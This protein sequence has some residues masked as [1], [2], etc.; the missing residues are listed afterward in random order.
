MKKI[1][2]ILLLLVSLGGCS[3][4]SAFQSSWYF[5]DEEKA[6][7]ETYVA[8]LNQG[9]DILRVKRVILNP[10]GDEVQDGWVRDINE[11]LEPGQVLLRKASGFTRKRQRQDPETWNGCR[12]PVG[13]V[14]IVGPDNRAIRAESTGVMP[15]SIPISWDAA[16]P[17]MNN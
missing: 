15:S 12:I 4:R 6:P 16:C 1:S 10:I 9:R 3:H 17:G 5:V 7:R 13:V 2:C 11:D 8:I 14:V